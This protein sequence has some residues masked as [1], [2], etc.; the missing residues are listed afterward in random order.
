VGPN[1][2]LGDMEKLKFLPPTGLELL[3]L[4]RPAHSQSLVLIQKK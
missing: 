1:V 2:D 3:P 4:D